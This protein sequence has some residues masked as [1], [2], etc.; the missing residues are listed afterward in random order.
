VRMEKSSGRVW[1]G[2]SAREGRACWWKEGGGR[3]LVAPCNKIEMYA[4]GIPRSKRTIGG[5]P[6]EATPLLRDLTSKVVMHR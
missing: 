2:V 3:G 6:M 1:V 5:P 4:G